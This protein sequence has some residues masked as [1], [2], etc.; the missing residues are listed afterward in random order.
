MPQEPSQPSSPG[1]QPNQPDAGTDEFE[2]ALLEV[3]QSLQS[4]KERYAQVQ[5]DRQRRAELQQRQ[6]QVKR[7]LRQTTNRQGLKAELKQIQDQLETI[8]L[9]LESQ[10]FSWGSL[11]E[12]FWQAVRFGGLGVVVGWILKSCAG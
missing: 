5:R 12:P 6:E 11:K 4:L 1:S 7:E 9:N 3:E 8:E 10:L 2:Q